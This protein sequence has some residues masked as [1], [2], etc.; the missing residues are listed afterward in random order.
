MTSRRPLA[1][2]AALAAACAVLIAAC[3]SSSPGQTGTN[4]SNDALLTKFSACMRSHGVPDFPDPS[5]GAEGANGF[6]IDGYTFNLPAGLNTSS[7]AYVS[8]DA[9]CGKPLR[10]GSG[11]PSRN[12]QMVAKLR[13]HALA[14]AECMRT[15]GVPNFP[16]PH[17]SSNGGGVTVASGGGGLDPTSPAFQRAEKDC[18]AD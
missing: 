5:T 9:T 18:G 10:A 12:P 3:G 6:G 13:E 16:D 11:G 14:H 17:V 7:P 2:T 15:H 8:A 4:A 1:V